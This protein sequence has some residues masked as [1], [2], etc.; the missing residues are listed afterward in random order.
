MPLYEH[1]FLTRQDV[2]NTQIEALTKEFSDVITEGGG[3]VERTEY[4][5]VKIPSLQNKKEPQSA[6]HNAQHRCAS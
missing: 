3:K 4:W 5:G 1:V 2:S 6:F